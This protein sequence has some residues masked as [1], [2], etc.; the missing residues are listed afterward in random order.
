MQNFVY[1]PQLLDWMSLS[2]RA[3]NNTE[4]GQCPHLCEVNS[5]QQKIA[6]CVYD[7][8]FADVYYSTMIFLKV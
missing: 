4:R 2:Q 5:Q 7:D 8:K 3:Q 6:R 1:F